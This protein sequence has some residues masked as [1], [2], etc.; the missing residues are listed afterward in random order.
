METDRMHYY[1]WR[2]RGCCVGKKLINSAYLMSVN[3]NTKHLTGLLHY[4]TFPLQLNLYLVIL[5]DNR[6][7]KIIFENVK[8][9]LSL[10]TQIKM[11]K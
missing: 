3:T 4:F 8:V 10:V 5:L 9:L 1:S 7:N 11:Q 2:H 6:H